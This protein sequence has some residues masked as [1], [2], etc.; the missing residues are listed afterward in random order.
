MR[1]LTF[2]WGLVLSG[3]MLQTSLL[4]QTFDWGGSLRWYQFLRLEDAQDEVFGERR[5][6]EFGSARFT[7]QSEWGAHVVFESHAVLDFLSPP[8]LAAASTAT[9]RSQTYLPL[10]H[11]FTDSSDYDLSGRFDRLNL[12]FNFENARVVAG[13]QAITWGVTYFWPVM[14]LFSSFAPERIDRDYKEGVDALRLTVPLGSFS[15]VQVVGAVLGRGFSDDQALAAQARLY[16]GRLDLGLMGGKFHGDTV[17]GFF[18]TTGLGG[19]ALRGEATWTDS[20]DPRDRLLGRS[21]FWR[22]SVGIDRQLNPDVGV[23]VEFS[24]NGFGASDADEYLLIAQADR[25]QRGEVNALGRYYTGA[26]LN[27]QIHPLWTFSNT[28]LVN[29]QDPSAFLI[30]ALQWSS[31]DNSTFLLGMQVGIGGQLDR[32]LSP[33]SEYGPAPATLFTAFTWYF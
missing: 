22:A 5:D 19:S 20:G 17:A 7:L 24:Y 27:W 21:S 30:P 32:T 25:V 18:I 15:E 11:D 10:Q 12:Q 14:D 31:S 26:A 8:M 2:I 33:R 13:R 4:A 16:L 1:R 6:T 28:L 3:S 23:T 29:W 9:G